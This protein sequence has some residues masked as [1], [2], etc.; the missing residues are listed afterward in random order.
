MTVLRRFIPPFIDGESNELE[1]NGS[2]FS[3]RQRGS[4]N[5]PIQVGVVKLDYVKQ[6]NKSLKFEAGIKGTYT[7]SS[8][9]SKIES[10]VDDQWVSSPRTSNNSDLR[11]GIGAAYSSFYLQINPSTNLVAGARYEYSDTRMDAEKEEN[12]IDRRFGKLFPSVFVSKK[13]NDKS[14]L[15]LS[16]TKRISR[17]SYNDLASFITY[18]DPIAVFT[19]NP[20]LRPVITN[21]VKIGYNYQGYS[22]SVLLSRD[23][24]PISRFQAA[25]NPAG[26][27]LYIAPQNVRYQNNLTFQTNL[28]WK[29]NNWWSMNAGFVGGWRQFKLAHTKEQ[30]EKT[31]FAYSVYGSQ[32]FLF[33]KNFSLEI[34]GWYNSLQYDGSKK[35]GGFGTLNA[36]I[37]KE[38]ASNKGSIQLS[39]SDLFRSMNIHTYFGYLTEE[40]FSLRSH[41]SYNTESRRTRIIKLTYAKSF[42]NTKIRG[43]KQRGIGSKDERDRVRKE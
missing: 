5:T 20:S 2:I 36:G 13:L 7:R 12:K 23:D 30:L 41:L 27:L 34:S 6:M 35:V 1:T 40:A 24:Y 21:N 29:V 4:A 42:G 33:L 14:E 39:V 31:Y 26:D 15:Q 18:N 17:P 8:G 22:F 9:L 19:G 43:Q 10:L 38:L 16:Y 25:A 3:T 28:P 11:E 37:K 32:T